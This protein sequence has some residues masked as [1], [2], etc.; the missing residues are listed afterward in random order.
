MA[1]SSVSWYQLNLCGDGLVSAVLQQCDHHKSV[2]GRLMQFVLA[3]VAP[4]ALKLKVL[5]HFS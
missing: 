4:S 1:S 3:F 2:R 5:F